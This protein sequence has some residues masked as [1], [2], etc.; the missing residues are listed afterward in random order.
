MKPV[1][2]ALLVAA[3]IAAFA[4][5]YAHASTHSDRHCYVGLSIGDNNNATGASVEWDDGGAVLGS[6]LYA[7]CTWHITDGWW[8][9]VNWDH[10]SQP[11]V[12]P[13]VNND[14]ESSVDHFG[15]N[16]EYRW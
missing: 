13:P 8:W 6:R 1:Y 12:G 16:I 10:L 15:V 7:G 4:Y 11:D 14:P 5:G 9:G 3:F 2:Y